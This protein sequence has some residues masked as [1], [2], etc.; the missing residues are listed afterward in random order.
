MFATEAL[1]GHLFLVPL[2]LVY[3]KIGQLI[4]I[5]LI[6]SYPGLILAD[7]TFALSVTIWLL[8]THFAALPRDVEDAAR[9]D[10]AGTLGVLP[11]VVV[12]IAGPRYRCSRRLHVPHRAG[13]VLFATVPT[14]DRTQPPVGLHGYATQS[15]V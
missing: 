8:A 1:P 9:V 13:R 11:P 5:E 2:F 10:G 3:A 15:I 7:L 14:D 6:G 4:G 12:P